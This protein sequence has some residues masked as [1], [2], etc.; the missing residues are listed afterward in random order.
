VKWYFRLWVLAMRAHDFLSDAFYDEH[1]TSLTE[2][3]VSRFNMPP[4]DAAELVHQI[5]LASLCQ[6][7][8]IQDPKV[9]F[10]GALECALRRRERHA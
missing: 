3:A 5:L 6:M 7:E 10:A 9:W 1:F 8:R 4:D 2:T